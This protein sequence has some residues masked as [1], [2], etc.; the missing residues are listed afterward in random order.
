MRRPKLRSEPRFSANKLAEY[1][2]AAGPTKRRSLIVDQIVSPTTKILNYEHA[3]A[4]ARRI[5]SDPSRNAQSWMRAA[6]RLRDSAANTPDEFDARCM[7]LSAQALEAFAPSSHLIRAGGAVVVAGRRQWGAL[8]LAGVRVSLSPEA[9][10]LEVGSEHRIGAIQFHFSRTAL[11]TEGLQYVAAMLVEALSQSGDSARRALCIAVDAFTGGVV[12]APRAMKTR[13][14]DLE[15]ACE[16]ITER[17]PA[18]YSEQ[19]AKY[20]ELSEG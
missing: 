17:W 12:D 18:L 20:A 3:R 9:S 8:T 16:E 2:T 13:M 1:M 14:R 15:S 6:S 5:L 10:L 7:R 11:K 19:L 4:A